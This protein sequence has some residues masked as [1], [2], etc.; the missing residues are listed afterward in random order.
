M[1]FHVIVQV[2]PMGRRATVV[3]RSGLPGALVAG[4]SR[5]TGN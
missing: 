3:S 1:P 5:V 4:P 2:S